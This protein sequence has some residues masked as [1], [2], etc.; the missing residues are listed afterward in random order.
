[1]V[2]PEHLVREVADQQRRPAAAAVVG[3]VRAHARARDARLAEGDA[4]GHADVAEAAVAA[5]L[6]E[7]VRLGVVGHEEIGPG[8]R[9]E[10]DQREPE[11]LGPRVLEPGLLG[12][13]L[14]DAAG[15]AAV[16]PQAL[17]L[18]G[19]RRA[20]GLAL[21]VERAEEILLDR[22][23]DV[24]GDH[25]VEPAVLVVVEEHG[26]RGEAGI[27]DAGLCRHVRERPAAQVAEQAV[28]AEAGHVQVD[29]TVVVVVGGRDPKP[30]HLD[31]QARRL[32]HVREMALAVVAIQ[33][34]Q[35]RLLGT[36][37]KARGVHEEDVLGAVAVVVEERDP[38]A[39]R[40]GQVLLPEGAA[41]VTERDAGGGRDVAEADA[42]S[43][44]R[45]RVEARKGG[46]QHRGRERDE[47]REPPH[48]WPPAAEAPAA[49]GAG[50]L[51]RRAAR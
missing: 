44:C 41:R 51:S 24:V 33:R 49:T 12:G 18:V 38:R 28:R 46:N 27:A 40:L 19:L 48:L 9:V 20:V 22:P 45:L 23:A 42:G 39:H 10:V 2:E 14:E 25:Q 37:R 8:V 36:A 6:V 4:R 31:R 30:I 17:A 35:A 15:K 7:L 50:A 16:E 47:R 13:V 26:A 43:G 3:R 11:R 21:P 32:G 1:M 34:R 29:A 5:I